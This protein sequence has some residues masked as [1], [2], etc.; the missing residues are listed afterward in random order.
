MKK[1]WISVK[2][3]LSRD[4]KHRQTMGESIWIFLHMLDTANWE[5]GIVHDWKDDA[6]AEEMNMPV[7]TLRE[8]RRKLD[9]LGYITCVKKQ[10][11]QDIVIHNW[12][13]PREYNGDVY[14]KKQSDTKRPLSKSAQSDI[15]SDIQSDTQT[16]TKHVMPTSDSNIKESFGADAP[17]RGMINPNTGRHTDAKVK[18]D[19]M[20]GI[21]AA[22]R[23]S[24]G[25]EV[26]L[27]SR[28]QEYPDDCQQTLRWF[29][30]IWRWPLSAIPSKPTRGG[31]G[32]EYALWI[33]E[34]RE[35]DN[36]IAGFGKEALLACVEPCAPLSVSHPLAIKWALPGEVGKLSIQSEKKRTVWTG[37]DTPFA[38]AVEDYVP[39]PRPPRP[40]QPAA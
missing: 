30:E 34:I 38:R 23:A 33:N 28:I 9:E 40:Q 32:G 11:T 12:T 35:I 5:T 27:T 7:R 39:S 22:A 16:N 17:Q 15:Q 24:S 29:V 13:N 25:L 4:P 21:L 2:C 31:K 6:A 20:D 37:L 26:Q 1:Q 3:G 19:P 10:Y 36:L 18:G 8:H 14:N